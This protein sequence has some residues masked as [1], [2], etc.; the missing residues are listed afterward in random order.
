[1]SFKWSAVW[2]RWAP[3]ILL[4]AAGLAFVG[5]VR[6]DSWRFYSPPV[7]KASYNEF[8]EPEPLGSAAAKAA[9]FG[10]TNFAADLYWLELIQYY[11]GGD[12]YGE[13]R[14][15]PALYNT[16]TDLSPQ[17]LAPYES[18]LLV[19]PAEKFV[20][21]GIALGEKGQRHLPSSWELPYYEGLIY[22]IYNKDYL[23]AA[24]LFQLAAT[25]KDA[26]AITKYFAGLYYQKANQRET[27]YVIFQTVYQTTKD[28]FVKDRARKQIG[29]LDGLFALQD[30]VKDYQARFGRHPA[31]LEELVG[32]GFI[33]A[34][35]VSP[36]GLRYTYD[37]ATGV[38]GDSK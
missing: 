25:K 3:L 2:P 15:L 38:V 13:Y 8:I 6:Y 17:F 33:Q 29:H 4:L 36:L 18:G 12:P 28:P 14:Q 9:S 31:S 24:K 32:R 10:A 37:A 22:H 16:I 5:E 19:L 35:P 20:S 11:G 7:V 26:P 27:A 34:V 30:A 21:Q 1:M 23:Q